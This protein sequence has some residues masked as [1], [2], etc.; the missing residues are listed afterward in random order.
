MRRKKALS[1]KGVVRRGILSNARRGK[2]LAEKG[3][4]GLFPARKKKKK[5]CRRTTG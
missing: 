3:V 2:Q 1:V 4:K 5:G